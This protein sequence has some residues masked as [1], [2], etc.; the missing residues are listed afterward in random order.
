MRRLAAFLLSVALFA[1]GQALAGE[2][3]LSLCDVP[4]TDAATFWTC[5]GQRLPV[6][7]ANLQGRPIAIGGVRHE[8]GISG[9]TGFSVVYNLSGLASGFSCLAGID[10]EDSPKDPKD[11][12]EAV[13]DV[14]LLVDRREAFRRSV[15]LGE[16]AVPISISLKGASQLELRGEYGRSGFQRQR[17]SF[18][19][20]VLTVDSKAAFLKSASDWKARVEAQR[21]LKPECP[22][23]PSWRNLKIERILDEGAGCLYKIS[24]RDYEII[25]APGFG[26]MIL[27]YG[28]PGGPNLLWNAF[29]VSQETPARGSCP[30]IGSHF[31]RFQPRKYFFPPDPLLLCGRYCVSFPSEGEILL[32]SPES[33]YLFLKQSFRIRLSQES[34]LLSIEETHKNI[35]PFPQECGVWSIT[36]VSPSLARGLSMP[37]AAAKVQASR[38]F[39]PDSLLDSLK[40]QG[41]WDSLEIGQHLLSS[42]G[43]K[44]LE[45]QQWPER[46]ELRTRFDGL[47]FLKSFEIPVDPATPMSGYLPGHFF[48][49]SKFIEI[50]CHGATKLLQPS[51]EISLS[52]A[53][54]ILKD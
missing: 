35:A 20:P 47:S 5:D 9:H 32:E 46:G 17:I 14:V 28:P 44:S 10:D 27:S 6:V 2:E 43:S 33:Y 45:W 8:R 22:E 7:D 4:W 3:A 36:R 24:A 1:L 12:V 25:V 30:D 51:E 54:R 23:A 21:S 39:Y 41:A 49:S 31:N 19:A 13:L 48:V 26:G 42:I 52:E 38:Q 34:S 37:R 53:W 18:A 15:K 16:K 40:G 11:S 50:E 29:K